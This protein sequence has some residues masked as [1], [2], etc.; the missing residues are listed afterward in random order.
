MSETRI[1]CCLSLPLDIGPLSPNRTLGRHWSVREKLKRITER[2]AY[3]VWHK[4]GKPRAAGPV[5]VTYT[6]RRARK[7]DG[8][9]ALSA[10][11]ALGDCLFKNR[12]TR[13]DSPE[14]VTFNP[15][16]QVFTPKSKAAPSV[17]VLVELL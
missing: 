5:I 16:V 11:K 13:D 15:V 4:A 8:D 10:C 1:V 12:I 7:L 9:N 2:T 3:A 6:V 14:W 17:D